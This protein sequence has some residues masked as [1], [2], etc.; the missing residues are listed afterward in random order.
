MRK[1]NREH[2]YEQKLTEIK[3]KHELQVNEVEQRFQKE[4]VKHEKILRRWEEEKVL[5]QKKIDQKK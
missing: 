2:E 1:S 4:V 3:A 5:N